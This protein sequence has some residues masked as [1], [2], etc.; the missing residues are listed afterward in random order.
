VVL[1]GFL[2]LGRRSHG[3]EQA[4]IG[5]FLEV[6]WPIATAW[7]VG[8]VA[9]RLY[10][11]TDRPWVRLVGTV[12]VAVTLGGLLRHFTPGHAMFSA[13]NIVLGIGLL[14]GTGGWRAGWRAV[15]R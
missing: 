8:A 3:L 11:A 13:F 9:L 1:A 12:V 2:L 10:T 7:V 4:G 14:I 5:W 6:L 15:R